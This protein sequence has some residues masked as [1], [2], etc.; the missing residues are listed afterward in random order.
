MTD[1]KT[2]VTTVPGVVL[3]LLD[4]A[5]QERRK[6]GERG[7]VELTVER[8][9]FD[10]RVSVI[11]LTIDREGEFI[12]AAATDG[13][14]LAWIGPPGFSQAQ[15]SSS[16]TELWR[17]T[18]AWEASDRYSKGVRARAELSIPVPCDELTV[19]TYVEW[20]NAIKTRGRRRVTPAMLFNPVYLELAVKFLARCKKVLGLEA[21]VLIDL[22]DPKKPAI[23]SLD[24]TE[25]DIGMAVMPL[26]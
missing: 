11:E 13:H 25:W 19:G 3:E 4:I 1:S 6:R 7:V 12:G 20:R 18:A 26:A 9:R 14:R 23:F 24:S 16:L 21:N 10:E 15:P 22:V 17:A 5:M 8:Q 2:I